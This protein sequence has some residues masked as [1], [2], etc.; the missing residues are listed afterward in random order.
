[1][2]QIGEPSQKQRLEG[3]TPLFYLTEGIGIL[4]VILVSVWCIH[5]RGGFGWTSNPGLEFNWHPF[6]MTFGLVFLYGNGN[7]TV[8]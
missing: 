5:F 8:L 3:F 2:D 6:L 7:K 1:M 4:L